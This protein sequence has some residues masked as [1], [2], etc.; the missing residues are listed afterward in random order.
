MNAIFQDRRKASRDA[1]SPTK[2]AP[3]LEMRLPSHSREFPSVPSSDARFGQQ[4]GNEW[5]RRQPPPAPCS[6]Y[7][8]APRNRRA[9]NRKAWWPATDTSCAADTPCRLRQRLLRQLRQR[10]L[11]R[12]CCRLVGSAAQPKGEQLR[13]VALAARGR[14]ESRRSGRTGAWIWG[15]SGSGT[16]SERCGSDPRGLAPGRAR[17]DKRWCRGRKRTRVRLF[18]RGRLE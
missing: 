9:I 13:F 4:L 8:S 17:V 11:R 7:R 2:P 1:G 5:K 18:G 16:G 14:R 12:G 10:L 6:R 3:I 15:G